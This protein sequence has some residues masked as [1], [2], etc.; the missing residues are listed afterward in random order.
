M[1]TTRALA[2][3]A[4]IFLLPPTGFLAGLLAFAYWTESGGA[5][6]IEDG[7]NFVF[8]L[9]ALSSTC[10]AGCVE[11]VAHEFAR[12]APRSRAGR[13]LASRSAGLEVRG[14]P[15]RSACSVPCRS[16]QSIVRLPWTDSTNSRAMSSTCTMWVNVLD[17]TGQATHPCLS[18]ALMEREA[19]WPSKG[20]GGS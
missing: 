7:R 20:A 10:L 9:F 15:C 14:E 5:G 3:T 19:L 4:A 12:L 11:G 16:V 18:R 8:V 2:I 1:T 13:A 17:P 6:H